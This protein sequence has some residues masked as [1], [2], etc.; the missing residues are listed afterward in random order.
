MLLIALFYRAYGWELVAVFDADP[1][2]IDIALGYFH[3]ARFSY[4][5]LGV[6]IVLGAA[7]QGR[8]PP[9]RRSC[10]TRP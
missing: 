10:S 3:R 2:V 1:R 6:G 9:C 7:I 5:G 8:A 4:I